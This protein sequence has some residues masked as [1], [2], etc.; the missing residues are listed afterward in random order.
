MTAVCSL[1]LKQSHILLSRS[2]LDLDDRDTK[3]VHHNRIADRGRS[4]IST[5]EKGRYLRIRRK[6]RRLQKKM[7]K[8]NRQTVGDNKKIQENK[9]SVKC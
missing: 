3:K 2:V 7:E 5:F 8:R 9:L 4:V 1:V 6:E